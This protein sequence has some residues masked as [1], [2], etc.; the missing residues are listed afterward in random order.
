MDRRAFKILGGAAMV[1]SCYY[2]GP[3]IYRSYIRMEKLNR[4]KEELLLKKEEYVEQIRLYDEEIKRLKIPF[5]R[6]KIAREKLF[7]A[8]EEEK[9][10]RIINKK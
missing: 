1:I 9:I 6:E 3:N 7:M 8:R 4:E 2:Y 5:Y 10:I